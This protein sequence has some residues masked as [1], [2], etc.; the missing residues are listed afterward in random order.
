MISRRIEKDQLH[1]ISKRNKRQVH[2]RKT[3]KLS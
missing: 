3:A 1:G 2:Y